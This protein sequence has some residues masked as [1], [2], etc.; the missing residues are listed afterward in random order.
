MYAVR[1]AIH[2]RTGQRARA[3]MVDEWL[4]DHDVEIVALADVY[5]ACVYL[6]KH[7]DQVPDLALVG[8]DWLSASEFA[9]VRYIRETWPPVGV[10]VYGGSPDAPAYDF[11]PLVLTCRSD[12]ALEGLWRRTPTDVLCRLAGEAMPRTVPRP[13]PEPPHTPASRP[14]SNMDAP[15]PLRTGPTGRSADEPD[16]LTPREPAQEAAVPP[17]AVL[18][19]EE[20]AALLEGR[21]EA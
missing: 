4:T 15:P 9:I 20:L 17:R 1:K 19:A 2:I 8:A 21:D 13:R 18:T 7:Y 5:E 14:T 12:Q 16:G 6:L 3:D 11:S 10:V